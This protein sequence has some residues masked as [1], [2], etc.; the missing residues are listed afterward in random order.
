MI[1]CRYV[2]K[3]DRDVP[4]DERNDD[5]DHYILWDAVRRVMYINP[6]VEVLFDS[7]LKDESAMLAWLDYLWW[8]RGIY[9]AD[10]KAPAKRIR[11]IYLKMWVPER[12][13]CTGFSHSH[14]L[15]AL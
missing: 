7:D 1:H 10:V 3:A 13:L 11:Q 5:T 15:P 6:S 9:F 14:L 2:E 8:E 4:F 12:A